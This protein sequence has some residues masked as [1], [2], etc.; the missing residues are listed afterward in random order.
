MR[1]SDWSSDVCSSDLGVVEFDESGKAVSI[2]EKPAMPKSNFAV[3]GLYFYDNQVV[4]IAKNIEPSLRGELEITDVN[5]VYLKEN[6]LN[7]SV[8]DRGTAW[9]DTGTFGSL[10]QAGQFV[11]VIESRQG[12]K[13][14]CIEEVAWRMGYINSTMLL[15]LA[16]PLIKSGYGEYLQLISS[17]AA[18]AGTGFQ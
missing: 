9:L 11:E 16:A 13:I 6:K 18:G 10:M 8:F 5:N 4:E 1:I 2:E 12:I 3:P 15:E 14:G 7:V 17:R